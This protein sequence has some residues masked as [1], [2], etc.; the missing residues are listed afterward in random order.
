[1]VHIEIKKG[2]DIPIA[3]APGGEMTQLAPSPIVALDVSEQVNL[4]LKLLKKEGEEVQQGEPLLADKFFSDRQFVAPASGIIKKV[5]RGEKRQVLNISIERSE[6]P[7]F[8]DLPSL[9][10]D[11]EKLIKEMGRA[12]LFSY[13]K[14]RP[15]NLIPDPSVLPEAIFVKGI[16][17]APFAPDPVTEAMRHREEF[18]AGLSV[19]SRL[20]PVHLTTRPNSSI[21]SMKDVTCHT[22]SGPHPA[23]NVSLHIY[24]I[25]PIVK[26]QQVIWTLDVSGV[27]AIGMM[28]KK[29]KVYTERIISVCGE[30]IPNRGFYIA[31]LGQSLHDLTKEWEGRVITG[32]LLMGRD[33]GSSGFL[34]YNDHTIWNLSDQ[35]KGSLFHFMRLG[36]GRYSSTRTYPSKRKDVL[37]STM[38]HGE[39]RPF[40]DGDIYQKVMPMEISVIELVKA[41]IAEDYEKAEELGLLEVAPEDFALPSFV[42]PSKIPMTDIVRRGLASYVEQYF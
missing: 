22:A 16:D 5:I 25:H 7:P 14:S 21:S 31:H 37:F 28:A 15:G 4:R 34:G 39:E 29:R 32:D 17:T 8:E 20:A 3:G 30:N 11:G 13:I 12:G 2:L 6:K 26:K 33:V 35:G 38:Q 36:K 42:C 40:V 27:I 10:C 41:L 9:H 1:M 23:G 18:Q 19:L 24:H